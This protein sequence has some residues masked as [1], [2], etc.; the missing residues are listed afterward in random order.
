MRKH[1]IFTL[2]LVC[3]GAGVS[4]A[5]I[6]DGVPPVGAVQQPAFSSSVSAQTQ[7][8]EQPEDASQ[9]GRI[10]TTTSLTAVKMQSR[11]SD[12][13]LFKSVLSYTLPPE[14]EN[15][16]DKCRQGLGDECFF[17]LKG[18]ETDANPAVAS[19]ANMEL[20]VLSMQRGMPK[21][22]LKYA[23]TAIKLT[24][25]DPFPVLSSGWIWLSLGKYKKARKA[26]ADLMY[27]TADFE[28]FYSA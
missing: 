3:L 23:Q 25:D 7:G 6:F 8:E 21:E 17:S 5:S 20:A 11:L 18:F 16:M 22:A 10:T 2:C 28:Y 14:F 27:L 9:P 4:Q 13:A 26:F 1:A 12:P 15:A 19:A 24:P